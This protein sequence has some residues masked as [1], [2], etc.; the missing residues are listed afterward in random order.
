LTSTPQVRERL[1]RRTRHKREKSYYGR[2]RCTGNDLNLEL[3]LVPSRRDLDTCNFMQRIGHQWTTTRRL[4]RNEH[5][6]REIAVISTSL[7]KPY[8]REL[9]LN[10]QK[11]TE[12]TAR[13]I[14]GCTG[15]RSGLLTTNP[16][17]VGAKL[18]CQAPLY[19][20]RT[21]GPLEED[22]HRTT[23]AGLQQSRTC[24]TYN[25]KLM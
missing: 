13:C 8:C 3:Q 18:C 4:P 9:N 17:G 10:I 14:S 5:V 1:R 16:P 7:R 12:G 6:E 22:P 20:L 2:K 19:V 11:L 24:L 15:P 23:G 25:P 21:R